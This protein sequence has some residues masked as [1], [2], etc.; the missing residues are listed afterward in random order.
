[1]LKKPPP[2]SPEPPKYFI[3]TELQIGDHCVCVDDRPNTFSHQKLL[4]KGKVY[5]VER[6][7]V[8]GNSSNVP[9][10]KEGFGGP[11]I[12]VEGIHP[13]NNGLWACDRFEKVVKPEKKTS[14]ED[15]VKEPTG[16]DLKKTK[17]EAY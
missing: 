11:Y 15:W 12:A 4:S 9:F 3:T 5:K 10:T 14:V 17:E 2:T 7:C 16:L 1:V 8:S 6:V 13:S